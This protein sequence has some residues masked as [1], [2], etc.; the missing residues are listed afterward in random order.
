MKYAAAMRFGGELVDAAECD[1]EDYKYLGLLCPECKDPVFLRAAGV[2]F[3]NNKEVKVGA[4]FCH[5]QSKDPAIALQC[6][7]R[8]AKYDK[9]DFEK[10][11]RQ[12]K[13]QRL[14]LLQRWFWTIFLGS[15]GREKF[16]GDN[17]NSESL[18]DMANAAIESVPSEMKIELAAQ[19]RENFLSNPKKL[20]MGCENVFDIMMDA[21]N[22]IVDSSGDGEELNHEQVRHYRLLRLLDRRLHFL[23]VQE[24]FAF[25]FS[26][27]GAS[28]FE[29]LAILA[30]IN[31]HNLDASG[32]K[33]QQLINS[34][35][36]RDSALLQISGL[37]IQSIVCIHW[38]D[39][40]AKLQK[41]SV[42]S[43]R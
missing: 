11:A 40:F 18:L 13:G 22:E 30:L 26:T 19:I 21:F 23:I 14:R 27:S 41:S 17:P 5:F 32:S 25:L 35:V 24:V 38:S 4:H 36:G 33:V 34:G 20:S 37:L 8:V 39:E 10:R 43:V 12:A 15:W 9:A 42:N 31:F 16:G 1:Y 7:S 3:Q 29:D 28:L 6:E 2:R